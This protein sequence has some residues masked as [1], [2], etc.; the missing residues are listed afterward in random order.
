MKA[1]TLHHLGIPCLCHIKQ[2]TGEIIKLTTEFFLNPEALIRIEPGGAVITPPQLYSTFIYVDQEL[3]EKLLVDDGISVFAWPKET[4]DLLFSN[5]VI[6]KKKKD[7]LSQRILN[8]EVS[9]LPNQV[10]FEVT[11]MCQCNCDHCY[12]KKDLGGVSP[13]LSILRQRVDKLKELGVGIFEITGGEPLLQEC[14]PEILN[15][16]NEQGLHFY[17]VTNG[18]Y[19]REASPELLSALSKGLGLAI[20]LDGINEVHDEVRHR[21]GLY[22]KLLEGLKIVADHGIN[23]YFISTLSS[24]NISS[25][26]GMI[27]LADK[28]KTTIHLRP[29]VN[30]GSAKDNNLSSDL[31]PL[32]GQY[33]SNPSVRNGLLSTKKIIP[34][35]KYYGCG[36]RKR[37]SVD[38]YGNLFPCVMDR[39]RKLANLMDYNQN[40]LVEDLE[41]ETRHFLKNNKK[42]LDCEFISQGKE[43]RCGGACRFSKF[44]KSQML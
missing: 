6:I 5:Q 8:V 16:I 43:L 31:R 10:L 17:V 2:T 42:C 44:Y 14:L 34:E 3:L 24:Y 12:H 39:D 15:Y 35:A 37:I 23:I 40:S 30:T 21:P 13:S 41:K 38:S 36:T 28:Y 9:G 22:N 25:I 29:A 19:L 18:E 33:L 27:A 1:V 7:G 11:P 32:I 4:F 20:S 26:P